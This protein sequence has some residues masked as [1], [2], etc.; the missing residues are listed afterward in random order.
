M[1]LMHNVVLATRFE[2]FKLVLVA[3]N[4]RYWRTIDM[5]IG[6][7]C[8]TTFRYLTR[9]LLRAFNRKWWTSAI[10]SKYSKRDAN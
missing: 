9:V 2:Y 3:E 4:K 8:I 1:Q 7:R 10:K 6:S 5:R